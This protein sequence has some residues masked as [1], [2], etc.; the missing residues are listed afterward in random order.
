MYKKLLTPLLLSSLFFLP[1][2]Q[3]TTEKIEAASATQ[4]D[5]VHIVNINSA[6][7]EQLASLQGIGD[8]KAKAIVDYRKTH[9]KF[10][11]INQLSNVKGIGAKL[12]EKN[13]MALSL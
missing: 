3:A 10:D 12:I 13:K 4:K 11:S 7:V 8:S 9:G 6:T 5:N 1:A 2:V